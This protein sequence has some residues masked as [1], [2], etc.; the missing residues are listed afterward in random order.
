MTR[1]PSP[2]LSNAE[3]LYDASLDDK[4][5]SSILVRGTGPSVLGPINFMKLK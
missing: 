5:N 2:N 1:Q 3:L 4:I